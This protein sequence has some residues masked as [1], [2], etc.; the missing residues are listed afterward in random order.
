[1]KIAVSCLTCR[2]PT[3]LADAL[4]SFA[5]VELPS[6]FEVFFLIVDNAPDA[7]AVMVVDAWR[8][9][10]PGEV[11]YVVE[12]EP[13][14]PWGRNRA[15]DEAV[16]RGA[17]LIAF[18]DDDETVDRAW[19]VGLVDYWRKTGAHILGAP[20]RSVP[21]K[22]YLSAFQRSTYRG[23]RRVYA[24]REAR[25]RTRWRF[26]REGELASITNNWLGDLRWITAAG[27]RFDTA[28][29]FQGGEDTQ[30][31]AMAKRRG[32]V[33]GWC[34]DAIVHETILPERIAL[35]YQYR[36]VRDQATTSFARKA[37]EERHP[38]PVIVT[39]MIAKW[40]LGSVLLLAAPLTAGR[41]L[42]D[43]FRSFGFGVGYWR[44]LMGRRSQHYAPGWIAQ[45]GQV[46]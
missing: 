21:P 14:I 24:R 26:G 7:P 1:M 30:F 10:L 18:I 37:A 5:A 17:D 25:N 38:L 2:R 40:M 20:V 6:G 46:F 33:T 32:A 12:P 27:L 11:V 43:G 4:A 35:R 23:I 39:T 28:L 34:P 44:A 45:R 42:V 16:A 19:L 36:R 13:G 9:R 8:S 29:S 22:A 31:F 15:L 41:T 3:L